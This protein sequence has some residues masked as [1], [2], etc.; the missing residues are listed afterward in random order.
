MNGSDGD[1]MIRMWKI[2]TITEPL[3]AGSAATEHDIR[4]Q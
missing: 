1:W 4:R 2:A 3:I